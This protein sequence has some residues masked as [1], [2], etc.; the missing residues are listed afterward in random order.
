[1]KVLVSSL[2]L[3]LFYLA[4][5]QIP[6]VF[7]SGYNPTITA[8]TFSAQGEL[9][10]IANSTGPSQ[11]SW[12]AFHPTLNI[13]YALNENGNRVTQYAISNG[14]LTQANQVSSGGSGPAHLMVHKNGKFLYTANYGNGNVGFVP[15]DTNGNLGNVTIY[16][17]GGQAHMVI[18]DP[19]GKYL[20]VA[21]K[22]ANYIA[23]YVIQ[24]NGELV[25]NSPATMPTAAGA[26]PRHLDFHPNGKYVYLI[27]ELSSTVQTLVYNSNGTLSSIQTISSIPN[28]VT[29]NTGAEIRVSPDGQFVYTSNRGHNSIAIFSVRVNGTLALVGHET[30]GGDISTPRAFTIDPTGKFLLVANQGKN[31][32]TVFSIN[33]STGTLTKMYTRGVTPSPTYV[34]FVPSPATATS[35]TVGSSDSVTNGNT[36][37]TDGTSAENTAVGLNLCLATLALILAFLM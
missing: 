36:G 15:L 18:T 10:S 26:G 1:M 33:S 9:Q 21:C 35:M 24:Q 23:Q 7:V 27:N 28:G 25:P 19:S 30:G 34:E 17:A 31:T 32:I 22:A 2:L 11:P 29:G 16:T 37:T 3:C 20:F 5:A 6:A 4:D 12:L 8:F 13:L 14:A